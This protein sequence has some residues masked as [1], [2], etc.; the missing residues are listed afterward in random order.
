MSKI[1]EKCDILISENI[2]SSNIKEFLIRLKSIKVNMSI[3]V[4]N[5]RSY[6]TL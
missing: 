1:P 4:L 3:A 6:G 5:W 2:I